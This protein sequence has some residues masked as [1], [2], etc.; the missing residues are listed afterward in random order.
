MI[1]KC[2]TANPP[3]TGL[4]S[5]FKKIVPLPFDEFFLILCKLHKEIVKFV[6][7]TLL[8]ALVVV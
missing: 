1:R 3:A 5:I 4:Q 2:N 7:T 6:K 8:C